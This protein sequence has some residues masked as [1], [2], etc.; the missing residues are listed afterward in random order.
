MTRRIIRQVK[1]RKINDTEW[2]ISQL[3]LNRGPVR[4]WTLLR[5]TFLSDSFVK[6]FNGTSAKCWGKSMLADSPVIHLRNLTTFHFQRTAAR[7]TGKWEQ[8]RGFIQMGLG[9]MAVYSLKGVIK[10]FTWNLFLLLAFLLLAW[11]RSSMLT[12]IMQSLFSY[13]N[14]VFVMQIVWIVYIM[15]ITI[16]FYFLMAYCFVKLMSTSLKFSE[17]NKQPWSV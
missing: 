15:E 8:N 10:M 3:S 7:E 14:K 9:H 6:L 1:K 17:T 2:Y 11:S 4:V 5:C 13:C 12:L 16:L